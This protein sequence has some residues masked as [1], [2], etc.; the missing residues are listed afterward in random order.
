MEWKNLPSW[1]KGGIIVSILYLII[2]LILI[3]YPCDSPGS[4][5]GQCWGL[6]M[7]FILISYPVLGILYRLE[8]DPKNKYLIL[9]A[10]FL[11][12]FVIGSIIGYIYGKIKS[13]RNKK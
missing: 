1:L 4:F 8:I 13:W 7:Y 9:I 10:T 11:V 6:E 3:K 2:G 12:Y 5:G